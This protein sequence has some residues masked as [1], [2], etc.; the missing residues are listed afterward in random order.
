MKNMK[1]AIAIEKPFTVTSQGR[2]FRFIPE[3]VG[4]SVVEIGGSGACSQGDTF[5]EALAM[6]HEASTLM[7]EF[8][9]ELRQ[10]ALAVKSKPARMPNRRRARPASLAAM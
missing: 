6:I 5:E 7:A 8:R 10:K 9:E 4:F 2:R 3:D 1:K